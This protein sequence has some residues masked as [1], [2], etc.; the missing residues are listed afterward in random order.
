VQVK[1]A[2][3]SEKG[4]SQKTQGGVPKKLAILLGYEKLEK[5]EQKKL[6]N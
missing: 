3:K 6:R 2:G 1:K 4:T 5:A